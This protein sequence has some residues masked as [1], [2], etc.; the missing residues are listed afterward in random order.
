MGYFRVYGPTQTKTPTIFRTMK[1]PSKT[2]RNMQNLVLVTVFSTV[3]DKNG[4]AI[5]CGKTADYI[6][7]LG[8]LHQGEIIS[9]Y[10]EDLFDKFVVGL[11]IAPRA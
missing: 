10:N 2:I 9:T 11:Q 8:V 7:D 1:S 3:V 6:D 5:R 4:V